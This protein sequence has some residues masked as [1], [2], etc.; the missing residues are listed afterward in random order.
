MAKF[1]D[2][3][4]TQEEAPQQAISKAETHTAKI[5]APDTVKKGE[6]FEITIKVG[7]HE[8]KPQHS[9][10]YAEVWFY[11]EGRPF[12][13]VRVAKIEWEPDYTLPEAKI[14]LTLQKPGIL[15]VI[16]YCNL[17]GLWEARKEIKVVE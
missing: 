15:Y 2:L 17:H 8:M 14:K 4:Y 3:I 5:E 6:A 9:I 11:E 1:G 13:P 10:R 12:N 16:T 7:P